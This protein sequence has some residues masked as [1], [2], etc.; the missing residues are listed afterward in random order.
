MQLAHGLRVWVYVLLCVCARAFGSPSNACSVI[1]RITLSS[2]DSTLD[3]TE[4]TARLTSQTSHSIQVNKRLRQPHV[5][6]SVQ[7]DTF[8]VCA[9]H[10]YEEDA[11]ISGR[12]CRPYAPAANTPIRNDMGH[13]CTPRKCLV[14]FRSPACASPLH[15]VGIHANASFAHMANDTARRQLVISWS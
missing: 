14:I 11:S 6:K 4:S 12:A 2:I 8:K 9:Q 7:E 1:D 15:T 3:L 5:V 13:A 10:H